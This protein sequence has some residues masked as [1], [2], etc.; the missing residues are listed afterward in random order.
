MA[1]LE[2]HGAGWRGVYRAP[3]GTRPKTDIYPSKKKAMEAAQDQEAEI[4]AGTWFNPLAGRITFSDYFEKQWYPNRQG[5]LRTKGE[6][7]SCYQADLKDS[8]GKM[9]LRHILPSTV[10]GWVTK[11]LEAG[12]SAATI[13]A[14]F[15]VLQ[16]CLAA[17]K[18]ASA[19]R[20]Q[21]IRSNPCEG[22]QL[23]DLPIR[24]VKILEMEQVEDVL[25]ALDPWWRLLPLFI[26]ETG[27]RW[28]EAMGLTVDSF[29]LDYRSLVVRRTIVEAKKSETGNGTRFA[30]KEVPKNKKTRRVALDV[31]VADAVKHLVAERKLGPT[32]RIFS[33]PNRR[34]PEGWHAPLAPYEWTVLRTKEWPEGLPIAATFHRTD[35]WAPAL[36]KAGVPHRT[37]RDLRASHISWLLAGGADLATVMQRVGHTRFQTTE[38]YTAPMSDADDRAL[39]AL[40]NLRARGKRERRETS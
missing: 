27:L 35:V 36:A 24:E 9:E 23:P 17:K 21:L 4:R 7:W 20:D 39:D 1:W 22:T 30:W 16:T 12:V 3:D 32:D 5:E 11:Q 18:G 8:F 19:R 15:K 14:R 38:R 31:D 6:Y 2:K 29:S 25:E 33:M 13:R 40:R 37:V 10:Q 28:G 26:S 34:A